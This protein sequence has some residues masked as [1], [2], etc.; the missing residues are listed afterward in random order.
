[1]T[2]VIQPYGKENLHVTPIKLRLIWRKGNVF[3]FDGSAQIEEEFPQFSGVIFSIFLRVKAE[4]D[5]TTGIEM[6]LEIVQ[7]KSPFRWPPPPLAFAF[8]VKVD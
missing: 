6:T 1:M 8:A 4:K 3:P 7:E 5:A 2:S